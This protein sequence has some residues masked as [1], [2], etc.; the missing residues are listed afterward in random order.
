MGRGQQELCAEKPLHVLVCVCWGWGSPAS[1]EPSLEHPDLRPAGSLQ[2]QQEA[3]WGVSGCAPEGPKA[4]GWGQL[5]TSAPPR[6]LLLSSAPPG[7][8]G[9]QGL[10]P[11]VPRVAGDSSP[12]GGTSRGLCVITRLKSSSP[13]P[14]PPG[15]FLHDLGQLP[16]DLCQASSSQ[17]L[18]KMGEPVQGCR[19]Q[20]LGG[21]ILLAANSSP[22]GFRPQAS[23]Y[24]LAKATSP[25]PASHPYSEASAAPAP[26]PRVVTTASIRP[27]VYQPGERQKGGEAVRSGWTWLL[28]HIP[29][30]SWPQAPC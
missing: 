1:Q 27:S 8:P 28:G 20:G 14:R 23:A 25:A 3:E 30:R 26:K 5:P 9:S 4:E 19:P 24:S 12:G 7:S 6:P 11:Y 21:A 10:L 22:L 2:Q 13:P 17:G 29:E 15:S 16:S 18:L